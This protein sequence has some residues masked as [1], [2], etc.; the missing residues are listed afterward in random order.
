DF[1]IGRG[2][3][4]LHRTDPAV[5]AIANYVLESALDSSLPQSL[6]P[7]RRCAA[8]RTS[9]VATRTTLLLVRYRF[10]LTLPSRSGDRALVAED[11]AVLAFEGSAT[12][13]RWLEANAVESLLSARATGNVP[14]GQAHNLVSRVLDNLREITPHLEEHG[15]E[16]ADRIVESHRRV[17]EAA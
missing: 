4:V 2:E 11:A 10:H 8:V 5:G 13:P 6:R 16:L 7:A 1:P 9:A 14:E 12:E 17:R 15:D 3:A